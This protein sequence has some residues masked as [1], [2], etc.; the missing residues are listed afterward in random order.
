MT[1]T[2][3]RWIPRFEFGE[4][5]LQL[6]YPITR[7]NPGA[8][9][10]GRVM[11]SASGAPGPVLTL[12]KYTLSF[13]LRFTEDEWPSVRDLLNHGQFGR[14]FLWAPGNA[15]ELDPLDTPIEVRLDAPRISD[16]LRPQRDATMPWMM[17]IGMSL[18][19]V[20]RLPWDLE[21]FEVVPEG[22]TPVDHID[23]TL[24]D[25][26]I[27]EGA[28][29]QAYA[30]V[31]DAND[32]VLDYPVA[33]SSTNSSRATV[34]DDGVVTGVDFGTTS[35]RATS[36]GIAGAALLT[37]NP[38]LGFYRTITI[39]HT[40]CG[41]ANSNNFVLLVSGT[42][43]YLKT[44]ANGGKVER[45]DGFD[46]VFRD[47]LN[48]ILDFH[49]ESWNGAT[50]DIVAWVRVPVLT[51]AADTTIRLHY[52]A[53][54]LTTSQQD[55]NGTWDA[56]YTGV[57]HLGDGVALS[58]ADS[59]VS[60]N[61][62]T[63]AGASAVAG[64]IRGG[65]NVGTAGA[66]FTCSA[67]GIVGAYTYRL[68]WR[69]NAGPSGAAPARVF[70]IGATSDSAGFSWSHNNAT[71]LRAAYQ[72][73]ADSSYV[74]AKLTTVVVGATWYHITVTWDGANLRIYLNGVL[75]ATVAC[76]SIKGILGTGITWGSQEVGRV[77]EM[78]LSKVARSASYI[79]AAYNNESNP[80]T[81]YALG[82]EINA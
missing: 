17:S 21:Y 10:V 46:I 3:L 60:A 13:A 7:W 71:F 2:T 62:L 77:D 8:R 29:T 6:T 80:A 39:D 50:G 9:T 73:R 37:V 33:W 25:N 23:V 81:F 65:A 14:S 34:D 79:L 55:E 58:L 70:Q 36:M 68:W 11:K 31:Y 69:A 67:A 72:Q 52:G 56:D 4:T 20:D 75:E 47:T 53:D 48:A 59:T 32:N 19:R 12:R 38:F 24:D 30:I 41:T 51:F 1:D 61:N 63:N 42:Y 66:K 57:Y 78:R 27:D 45:A 43:A 22:P 74:A 15:F 64:Q 16:G 49:I 40:K 54:N 44:I 76:A 5:V 82:A 18:T 35:I 28:T 26:S